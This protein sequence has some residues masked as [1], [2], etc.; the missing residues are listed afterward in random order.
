MGAFDPY[1]QS[2]CFFESD[3]QT[4]IHVPIPL[5][6]A[7]NEESVSVS[8]NYGTQL[9]A[10][11]IMLLVLLL[12]TP[13]D[14]IRR[15]STVLYIVALVACTIRMALLCSFF[16]SPFN[17]F[18]NYW[19]GNYSS[20]GQHHFNV[21]VAGNCF[22]ALLVI[23]I[24]AALMNQ[25]WTMVRLWPKAAKYCLA[26]LS[27]VITLFT[28]VWRLIYTVVLTQAV[29]A[30]ESARPFRWVVQWAIITNAVSICWFCA[31]FNMKLI[32][33]L[34][35]HRSI[36]PSARSLAPMDVLVMTNGLLMIIPVI[37]TGLE[38]GHW[39]NFESAS[40]TLTSVTLILPMGTLAAQRFTQSYGLEYGRSADNR[41]NM[42]PMI[43]HGSHRPLKD[44][45]SITNSS[46]TG[47]TPHISVSSR[48][49]GGMVA[50]SRSTDPV[51]VEL[52]Q[53]DDASTY[54][55]ASRVR[56]DRELEQREERL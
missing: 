11:V 5:I 54:N 3:G 56:V 53:I 47:T 42:I 22:S 38:W 34:I 23:V 18:Y 13:T 46:R 19:A 52:G 28:I 36:L 50:S 8:I 40:L 30:A 20:V 14:R 12:M 45:S 31:L 1:T 15:P 27:A 26:I 33:H 48:C 43:T 21:S 16:P 41:R 24:E 4:E 35:S 9:G 6:D 37:F 7:F 44:A 49:E 39:A 32:L 55:T 10:C 51:D 2:V 17:E 25:A 29:F